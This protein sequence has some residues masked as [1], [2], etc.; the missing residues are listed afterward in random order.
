M[1]VGSGTPIRSLCAPRSTRSAEQ[2]ATRRRLRRHPLSHI[3]AASTGRTERAGQVDVEL[4]GVALVWEQERFAVTRLDPRDRADP[5]LRATSAGPRGFLRTWLG[6][7]PGRAAG[8]R[9]RARAPCKAV[10]PGAA[11]RGRRH[12]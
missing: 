9:A 2:G 1:L 7:H 8:S 11:P 4:L 3:N 5:G 10:V 6:S 12:A